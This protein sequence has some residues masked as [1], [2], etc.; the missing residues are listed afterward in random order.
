MR[1]RVIWAFIFV[2]ALAVSV[3][4]QHSDQPGAHRPP[5]PSQTTPQATPLPSPEATPTPAPTYVFPDRNERFRRYLENT[6]GPLRLARIG[7]SAGISQ[8]NEDPKEWDR[9]FE[10]YGRRYA[11]DFGRN[12]I[13]QTV[14][15]GL[16]EALHLDSESERSKHDHFLPRLK[17]A[18]LENITSRTTTGKRVFSIPKVAGTYAGAVISV[19]T[20]YP[21]HYTYKDGLRNGSESLLM[22]FGTS[23]VREFVF[24]W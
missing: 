16:D 19:E 1:K 13:H 2:L 11:S 7:L 20:W 10:G 15:Y 17:D 5:A 6:I 24:H 14:T 12:A 23:V 22:G 21:E 4:S 8:W 18:L 3:Y 9:E